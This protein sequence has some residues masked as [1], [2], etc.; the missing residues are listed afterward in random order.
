MISFQ[1]EEVQIPSI[2]KPDVKD[3]IEKVIE[4]HHFIPGE[5][6]YIFCSDDYILSINRQYLNHDYFT[7]IITFDYRVNNVISGDLI[8]SLDTVKSNANKYGDNYEME[9]LR[10]II[11]GILHLCGFNDKTSAESQLM[12]QLEDK[13]LNLYSTFK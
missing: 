12:R 5:L 6:N 4:S 11:H 3:W 9:L 13:A 7:D 10:V 8:I 2:I 1:S